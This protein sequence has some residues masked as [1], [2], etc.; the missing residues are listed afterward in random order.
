[1]WINLDHCC[2]MEICKRY[3]W[4]RTHNKLYVYCEQI[5]RKCKLRNLIEMKW[6][7]K[8]TLRLCT[9]SNNPIWQVWFPGRLISF[10]LHALLHLTQST[11]FNLALSVRWKMWVNIF[12][13]LSLLR[14]TVNKSFATPAN[15]SLVII[16]IVC[17]EIILF[18]CKYFHCFISEIESRVQQIS[19]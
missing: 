18:A 15:V 7:S 3:K 2:R 4:H 17:N 1:M 12:L 9:E 5:S 10:R 11:Y 13:S 14:W 6:R 8:A 16:S 19:T